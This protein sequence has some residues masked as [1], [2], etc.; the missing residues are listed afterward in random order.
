MRLQ[1]IFRTPTAW[2]SVCER[3]A[4][5][6]FEGQ[7]TLAD[8]DRMHALGERWNLE[9]PGKRVELVV[10]FPSDTR[11]NLEE[12]TRMARLIKQ[13]EA[14]RSASATVLLAEGILAS[15]HRSVLTGMM[16]LAPAPHPAKVFA[17]V[18]HALHW[19]L[20]HVRA[21]LDPS[22]SLAELDAAL[23][24]NLT[25]FRARVDRPLMKTG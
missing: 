23:D 10:V 14:H 6:A 8:M 1:P 3:F 11:M 13:G 24:E 20:P 18:A 17:T 15:V 2:I 7:V 16:L 22:L 12:R 4:V 21:Q 5:H 19:L 9:H 25:E